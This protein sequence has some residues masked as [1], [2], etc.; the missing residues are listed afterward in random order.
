M[1]T[2]GLFIWTPPQAF[3][4]SAKVP[5]PTLHFFPYKWSGW[6]PCCNPALND[7]SVDSLS[8]VVIRRGLPC[9][10]L[11]LFSDSLLASCVLDLTALTV[12]FL[13]I[14]TFDD[15]AMLLMPRYVFLCLYPLWLAIC[16]TFEGS[17][18]SIDFPPDMGSQSSERRYSCPSLSMRHSLVSLRWEV[19]W[20]PSRDQSAAP[21]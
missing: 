19:G 11:E 20:S 21:Y 5:S 4:H 16:F 18:L 10:L 7:E 3:L 9:D 8:V 1:E 14:W 12:I 2:T 15:G 17:V 13:I 6:F